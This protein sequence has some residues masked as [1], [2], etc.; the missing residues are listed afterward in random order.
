MRMNEAFPSKYLR[1]E[2]LD[3]DVT[4]AIE[5]VELVELKDPAGTKPIE[6]KP[7]VWIRG[8]DKPFICNKTNYKAI[9]KII[10]SDDTEDWIGK[11]ITLTVMDVDS[12]GEMVAA[13]RVKLPRATRHAAAPDRSAVQ[14]HPTEP[15]TVRG[16]AGE[17]VPRSE[18]RG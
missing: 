6:H 15:A 2:D 14:H 8:E 11:E 5:K 18:F 17:E 4:G 10:G 7:C 12:F 16:A 1:A 9:S 13:I 3:M